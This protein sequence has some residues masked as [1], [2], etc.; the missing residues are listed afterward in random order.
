MRLTVS[1]TRKD[2]SISVLT[3]NPPGSW[4]RPTAASPADAAHLHW[5]Q[6]GAPP[7]WHGLILVSKSAETQVV[8]LAKTQSS[9]EAGGLA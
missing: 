1:P 9:G 8:V 7:N 6:S 5:L 3:R 4:W 2:A